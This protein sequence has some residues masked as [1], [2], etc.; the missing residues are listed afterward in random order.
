MAAIDDYIKQVIRGGDEVSAELEKIF[1]QTLRNSP[2][3]DILSEGM[4]GVKVI[5]PPA[6]SLVV[7]CSRG[8]DPLLFNPLPYAASV[9][10]LRGIKASNGS[11]VYYSGRE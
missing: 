2:L 6:D 10:E 1:A 9:V 5:R 8:G 3:V 4:D 11:D 7:V